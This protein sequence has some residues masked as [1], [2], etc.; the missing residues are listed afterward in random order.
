MD[1]KCVCR[2]PVSHLL[3]DQQKHLNV[4]LTWTMQEK[5]NYSIQE[6]AF[7]ALPDYPGPYIPE[8]AYNYIHPV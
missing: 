6:A 3:L 8:V 5:A 7:I 1:L 2:T 4:L